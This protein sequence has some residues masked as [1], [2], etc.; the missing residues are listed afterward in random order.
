MMRRLKPFTGMLLLLGFIAVIFWPGLSGGFVFDDMTNITSNSK[1]AVKSLNFSDLNAAAWSGQAGPLKRPVSMLSFALNHAFSGFDP[2][3]FKLTNLFIHLINTALVGALAYCVFS[4][5]LQR[6]IVP[7]GIR[8]TPDFPMW[9]AF[10]AAA[11]WGTH[12]L[13]LTSVLYVVQRMTSLSTL[14]GLA[15]LTLYGVWRVF[16]VRY[17]LGRTLG[18]AALILFLLAASVLSKESGLLFVPLLI[19]MELVVFQGQKEGRPLM[20]GRFSTTRLLWMLCALGVLIVLWKLPGFMRPENFYNRDFTLNERLLTEARVLFYYLRLFFA[21]SLSE[22]ALFHDDFLI[23]TGLLDPPSTLL[24]L[25]GL[26]AITLGTLWV[27]KKYPLLWFAWGWFLISHAMESTVI[28]LELVHEHRNYF[29]TLGFVILIPWLA[30]SAQKRMRSIAFLLMG[31]LMLIF[32]FLTWQRSELWGNLPMLVAFEADAHPQSDSTRYLLGWVYAQQ[33]QMTGDPEFARSALTE[34][35]RA[36]KTYKPNNGPWFATLHLTSSL[37]EPIAPEIV[38]ELRQR[39]REG[40]AYNSNVTFLAHFANCQEQGHCLLPHEDAV[41]FFIAAI[42]NPKTSK[43][44]RALLYQH[45]AR[46][47]IHVFGDVEKGEELLN[48]ALALNEDSNTHLLFVDLYTG[49]GHLTEARQHLERALQLDSLGTDYPRAMQRLK[50][51]EEAE[52]ELKQPTSGIAPLPHT[53][54]SQPG[55]SP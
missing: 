9:G 34:M 49:L 43:L 32:S 23:S 45:A 15:A 39:L 18:V 16:P 25:L 5:F 24:A 6:R 54:S 28:S 26:A 22:L 35:Q 36:M 29:A 20:L 14:F 55:L 44:V 17:T 2:Y 47:Y 48:N 3:A 41:S 10:I 50:N 12:P 4:G 21:P 42:E 1:I 27:Y 19:F 52:R 13:N 37:K 46:Y 30:F 53:A 31:G 40:P 11:F 33:F 7:E 38:E 8:Q 51:I